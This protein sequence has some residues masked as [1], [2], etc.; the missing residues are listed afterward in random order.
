[1]MIHIGIDPGKLGAIVVLDVPDMTWT[2]PIRKTGKGSRTEI[3]LEAL[4]GIF[5]QIVRVHGL[6][7]IQVVIE[8]AQAMSRFD[9]ILQKRV[10]QGAVS[11]FNTGFGYGV[12]K[13]ALTCYRFPYVEVHPKT[14]QKAMGIVGGKGNDT[15]AQSIAVCK[16]RWPGINLKRTP[17]CTNDSDGISDATLLAAY[18]KQI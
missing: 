5:T 1:M 9:P 2:M 7:G 13:M 11:N 6:E 10:P 14:W 4:A 8:K 16:A 15:K 17:R 18:G 3:D 12:L